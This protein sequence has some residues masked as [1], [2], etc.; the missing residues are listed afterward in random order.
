MNQ[1]CTGGKPFAASDAAQPS[2]PV[3]SRTGTPGGSLQVLARGR[4]GFQTAIPNGRAAPIPLTRSA[5]IL[6]RPSSKGPHLGNPEHRLNDTV[7]ILARLRRHNTAVH[8]GSLSVPS[9][10]SW[11]AWPHGLTRNCNE[12]KL[13]GFPGFPARR[14]AGDSAVG[15]LDW[16]SCPYCP[17]TVTDLITDDGRP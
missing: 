9:H 10:R 13:G 11:P 1:P 2:T 6:A 7:R 8:S 16:L 3:L 12:T 4:R 5:T 17:T 15:R 14:D